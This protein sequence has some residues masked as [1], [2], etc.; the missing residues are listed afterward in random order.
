MKTP[1]KQRIVGNFLNWVKVKHQNL[2]HNILTRNFRWFSLWRGKRQ[3]FPLLLDIILKA[4]VYNKKVRKNICGMK[5]TQLD[6][7]DINIYLRKPV[8]KNIDW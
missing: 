1:R 6:V 3:R 8:E 4:L 2:V 5:E 7:S